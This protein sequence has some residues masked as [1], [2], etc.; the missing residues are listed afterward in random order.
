MP[1]AAPP[2]SEAPA[3]LDPSLAAGPQRD[4]APFF[5]ELRER[6][7]VCWIP[8]L[9][10]WLVT[11]HADVRD[12]FADARLTADPRAWERYQEPSDERTRYWLSEMPFRSTPSDPT[13]LGRRLV[14]AALT[15]RAVTRM[16]LRMQEVVEQFA[17]PLRRRRDVVDLLGEFTAPVSATVIGRILGIPPKDEDLHVFRQLAISATRSINPILSEKKRLKAERAGAEICEYVLQLVRR[18]RERPEEDLISDLVSASEGAS[19]ASDEDVARVVG[20]LVSAGTGTT[21]IAAARAL[22]TLFRHPEQLALLRGD[23]SLLPEAVQELLRFDSGL[24]VM[25]RYVLEDFELRGRSIAKGQLMALSMMGANRD[26]R[27]FDEPDQLDL[28]RDTKNALSFGHGAHFCIGANIARAELRLMLGA[29]LDFMPPGARLL[30]DRIRWSARG[31][32]SNVRELPV[33]FG[34]RDERP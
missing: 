6:D 31:V 5:A 26:P 13:S 22:R 12:L 14:S 9:D 4:P 32:M 17:A 25:P 27:A 18:R 1:A 30:E 8:G 11:R 24:I 3:R 34:A 33:D 7:P 19:P 15:P 2:G 23:R 28:R 21:S 29:A 10:A 16:E 20:G